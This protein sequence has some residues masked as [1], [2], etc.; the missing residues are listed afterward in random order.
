MSTDVDLLRSTLHLGF[1]GL[2]VFQDGRVD[3]AY[4][5]LQHTTTT[6][7]FTAALRSGR[8]S[9]EGTFEGAADIRLGKIRSRR[10]DST[11][12][13]LRPRSAAWVSS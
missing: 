3:I 4:A 10:E 8:H 9:R 6:L 2:A 5:V 1:N 12:D 11:L 7:T 13:R